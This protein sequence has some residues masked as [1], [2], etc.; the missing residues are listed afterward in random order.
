MFPL[1]SLMLFAHSSVALRAKKA[2]RP[3]SVAQLR[4][5]EI[6]GLKFH[7]T[8]RPL[9]GW[10]NKTPGLTGYSYTSLREVGPKNRGST[11]NKGLVI[12]GP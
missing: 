9:K 12:T 7:R 10:E 8:T 5:L 4:S 2:A 11:G 1:P 3:P 6:P